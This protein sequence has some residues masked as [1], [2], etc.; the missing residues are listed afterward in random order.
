MEQQLLPQMRQEM[1]LIQIETIL[2]SLVAVG[3]MGREGQITLCP[4]FVEKQAKDALNL[5][6][7]IFH[8]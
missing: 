8:D 1:S 3:R 5:W 4:D 6:K 7:E 2:K